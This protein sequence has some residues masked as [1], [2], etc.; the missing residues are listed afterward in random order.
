MKG[1]SSNRATCQGDFVMTSLIN[2]NTC[3]AQMADTAPACPKCG[4][5]GS[6]AISPKSGFIALVLCFFFGFFGVHN[7]YLGRWFRGLLQL[8]LFGLASLLMAVVV[9]VLLYVPL[10][11]WV[12]ME[13]LFLLFS[14]G[15]DGDGLRVKL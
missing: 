12:F 1:T 4:A 7:L 13:F 15:S 2:C 8:A 10:G 6:G 14:R 5:V 11:I 9:G 3:G